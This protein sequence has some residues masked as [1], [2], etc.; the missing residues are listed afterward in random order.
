[1][2]TIVFRFMI[3]SNVELNLVISLSWEPLKFDTLALAFW[4]TLPF[5]ST[6]LV[7]K[8]GTRSTWIQKPIFTCA[9]P[10]AYISNT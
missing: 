3:G 10:D 9:E 8:N 4:S 1:M 5:Y 6:E 7:E 2:V